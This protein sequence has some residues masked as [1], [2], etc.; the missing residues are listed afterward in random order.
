MAY[1]EQFIQNQR[2]G[3]ANTAGSGKHNGNRQ[4]RQDT[5]STTGTGKHGRIMQTQQQIR[6]DSAF[7]LAIT[8]Q[9]TGFKYKLNK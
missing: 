2:L 6:G 3:Q 5:G 7:D 9:K 8:E 1:S 4:T